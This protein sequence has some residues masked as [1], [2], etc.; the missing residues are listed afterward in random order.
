M[1][2]TFGCRLK[3][4]LVIAAICLA[5]PARAEDRVNPQIVGEFLGYTLMCGCLPYEP[6]HLQAV[7]YALLVEEQGVSYANTAAGYMHHTR[8][9]FYRNTGTFCSSFI[10]SNDYA[11]YMGE[12]VAM[13]DLDTEPA[14]FQQAYWEERN[15][16]RS[17]SAVEAPTLTQECR[18]H[19]ASVGCKR[20]M[21]EV[22]D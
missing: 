17:D 6:D 12:I 1:S 5:A 18:S 20:S 8:D 22:R 3:F 4:V 13:I 15:D 7:Y 19:P 16:H 9:G 14:D 11:L 10:C 2:A 21:E